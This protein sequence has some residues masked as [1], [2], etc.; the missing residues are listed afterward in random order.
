MGLVA[1]DATYTDA[2]KKKDVD[3]YAHKKELTP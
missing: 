2:K 3:I 1:I